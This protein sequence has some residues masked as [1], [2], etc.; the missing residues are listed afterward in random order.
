[1]FV[2]LAETDWLDKVIITSRVERQP[3][4]LLTYSQL[5]TVSEKLVHQTRGIILSVINVINVKNFHISLTTVVIAN[6]T[7]TIRKR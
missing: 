3:S 7:D 6:I 1:M 2:R 4:L 5:Y